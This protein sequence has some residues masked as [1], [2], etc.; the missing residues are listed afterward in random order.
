MKKKIIFGTTAV[1]LVGAITAA[2][3]LTGFTG[4]EQE[5]AATAVRTA[6]LKKGD[7][8]VSVSA[9]GTVY[10]QTATSVYSE[11]NYPVKTVY[12]SV[13]DKVVAGDLLAELDL[14][15][16]ETDIA[17]QKASLNSSLAS[18]SHNLSAAQ[19]DLNTY[20]KNVEDGND[21]EVLNA[22]TSVDSAEIELKNAQLDI[23]AAE[24]ELYSAAD[25]L[26]DYS[27][28]KDDGDE[29]TI[30]AAYDAYDSARSAYDKA[31]TSLEKAK[32]SYIKAEQ[33]LEK[34]EQSYEAT[35]VS[36]LDKYADYQEKVQSA[37]LNTDFTEQQLSLDRL[38]AELSNSN[39]YAPV[40]GTITEVYAEPGVSGSGNGSSVMFIIQDTENLKVV[41][42]IMEYDVGSVTIGD[43]VVVTTDAT[44]DAE[45]GG[46]L[47]KIAPTSTLSS[48]GEE[49]STSTE[50]EYQSEITVD[51]DG[52]KQGI[53]IGMNAQL[54]IVT[55]ER[56]DVFTVLYDAVVKTPDRTIIYAVENNA[57][58]AIEVTT[59]LENDLYI[60]VSG[61][62][63]AEGMQI[64]SDATGIT[65]GMAVESRGS[66]APRPENQEQSN[67]NGGMMGMPGMGGPGG[68]R[69]GG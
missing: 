28:A 54:S 33:N 51:P 21:T 63:L 50:A 23:E 64:I 4:T 57:A 67:Q 58:K 36:V 20:R 25:K 56:K 40:S 44:G 32:S 48:T 61:D 5:T 45:I 7:L 65:E 49:T 30:D 41:A 14:S 2:M 24:T 52:A 15:D 22:R 66:A 46:T 39:I 18:A 53:K 6:E 47:S 62:G 19:N 31:S 55:E 35:K 38:E 17:Q 11:I 34:A 26:E 69:M 3:L 29:D 12:V 10:S 16:L 43:R 42:N 1:A 59:G 13:G 9:S 68:M 27:D 8:A 37:A 60:E